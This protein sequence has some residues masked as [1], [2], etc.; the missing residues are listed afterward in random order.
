EEFDVNVATEYK[1]DN[2]KLPLFIKPIDGSR[3]IDTYT[4]K[5]KD[6][7]AEYHFKNEKLMFLEYLDHNDYDEFT[8]DLYY[9]KD[10]K[11]KCVVPRK[12]IEIREGE[13]YKAVTAKN[14]L[15]S[16]LKKNLSYIS[17]AVGCITAQ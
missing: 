6:Y 3:S 17:G 5:S 14:T 13:V 1:K 15:I 10:H 12:R 9:S 11:L 4:I 2:Y 16:Y 8:C 7:F